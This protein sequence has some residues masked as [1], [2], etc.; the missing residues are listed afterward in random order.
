ME[1]SPWKKHSHFFSISVNHLLD[2]LRVL[3]VH[4]L[5]VMYIKIIRALRQINQQNFELR[6]TSIRDGWTAS[7]TIIVG[8]HLGL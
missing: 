2:G 3:E 6:T 7:F 8:I 5:N 4:G 1:K